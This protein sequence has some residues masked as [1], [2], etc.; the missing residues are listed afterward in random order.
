M[1]KKLFCLA[2]AFFLLLSLAACGESAGQADAVQSAAPELPSMEGLWRSSLSHGPG[3]DGTGSIEPRSLLLEF[4][5]DGTFS[6]LLNEG[7]EG[8]WELSGDAEDTRLLL[9]FEYNG[10]SYN[11]AQTIVTDG[12]CISFRINLDS[13]EHF[14][15]FNGADSHW[16]GE[17]AERVKTAIIPQP[18][19]LLG[20]WQSFSLVQSGYDAGGNYQSGQVDSEGCSICFA[21]DGS[22]KALLS[23]GEYQGTWELKDKYI[24]GMVPVCLFTLQPENSEALMQADM[25]FISSGEGYMK[26]ELS[27]KSGEKS[28]MYKFTYSTEE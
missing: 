25:A 15:Y 11:M 6:C 24:M 3:S 28:E 26:L 5:E 4:R 8:T 10:Q 19:K 18:E 21:G 16:T 23:G 2:L 17:S 13:T 22:F 27:V 20:S 7:L 14:Y 1:M 12:D 9:D